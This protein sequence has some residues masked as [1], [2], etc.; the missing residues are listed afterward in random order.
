MP[1]W[2][3]RWRGGRTYENVRSGRGTVF[4]IEKKAHGE[5]YSIPLAVGD[6]QSAEAELALFMRDPE[7]YAAQ[8]AR[9]PRAEGLRIDKETIDV[10][11]AAMRAENRTAPYLRDTTRALK[12]WANAFAGRPLQTVSK[13]DVEN[14][15]AKFGARNHR[16]AALKT[17]ATYYVKA[18]RLKAVENPAAL[19]EI[20]PPPAGKLKKPKGYDMATVMVHYAVLD[21]QPARDLMLLRLKAGMHG[22][23][24]ERIAA[25]ECV[26]REVPDAEIAGTVTFVHKGRHE[27]AVS[28]DAQMLAAVR[29]IVKAGYAPGKG[30][31]GK[32][33]KRAA[34]SLGVSY[35]LASEFRHSFIT[36]ATN[37]GE[38][39]T[40]S[41]RGVDLREVQNVVGHRSGSNVTKDHY[42]G[43]TPPFIRLARL[44]LTHPDD[45]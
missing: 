9:E 6:K 39:V 27:H 24:V 7:L 41:G 10:V 45:P 42:V 29:R 26:V 18:G 40:V 44:K 31:M 11:V 8:N 16:L 23:E 38:K 5:R 36:W 30:T 37:E 13:T 3:G 1:E 43:G 20:K 2:N 32:A 25:G 4:V 34:K 12:D 17:F 19:V 22:S 14:A 33:L 28:L 21:T 15:L 35:L